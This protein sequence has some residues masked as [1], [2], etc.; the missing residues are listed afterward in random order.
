MDRPRAME[1]RRVRCSQESAEAEE[2][3]V[4][5]GLRRE[6]GQRGSRSTSRPRLGRLLKMRGREGVVV[7]VGVL[8]RR[9]AVGG[10][11]HQLLTTFPLLG[12][13]GGNGAGSDDRLGK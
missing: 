11:A 4:A 7:A 3:A 8:W 12:A 13:S 2:G 1:A 5:G 10:G 9:M 6:G